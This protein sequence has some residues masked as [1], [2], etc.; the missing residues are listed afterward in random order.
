MA[1][2]WVNGVAHEVSVGTRLSEVLSRAPHPCGGKGICG[3]CRVRATGALSPL[4]REEERHLTAF[5]IADD[6][7]L[8]CCAVVE[9]DCRVTV[10]ADSVMAVIVDGK[11][12]AVMTPTFVTYGV[13]VDVGTTTL[14]ARL[15]DVAG[16]LLAQAGGINPQIA[17]GADILSRIQ[18]AGEGKDLTTPLQAAVNGLICRLAEEAGVHTSAIDGVVITGNTAMLC[19]LAGTDPTPLSYAPFALPHAFHETVT[20]A[21][22]GLTSLAPNRGVYLPPCASAF[23]GADALCAALACGMD[24]DD[25]TTLLA[26][27]GTNG[28][29]LLRHKNTLYACSTAAGPAFEGVGISCGMP[30]VE[31][32][33]DEVALVNGRLLSHTIGGGKAKGICGSGL[34]DAAACLLVTEEMDKTGYLGSVAVPLTENLSLTQED[35]RALQQAKAAVGA[36][37]QT[38][39][40]H[41]D[42]TADGVE[43]L[44]VAGGFGSR[45]NGR[46][47]AAIGLLPRDLATRIQPVGNAALDGASRLL[48]DVSAREKLTALPDDIHVIELATDL[49]FTEHFIKNMTF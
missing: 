43:V 40:H 39:L 38:L 7:R 47:A 33:I 5:E 10:E 29:L 13:A 42:L 8:S 31:G 46:N 17:F 11:P 45:L 20:A 37:L 24:A 30:A 3:K 26:D 19:F 1:T 35:V 6:I 32:A 18:T 23:I 14:A 27:M 25:R 12:T 16:R 22:I 28:E 34:V 21:A 15:Y 36:G 4:S 9:G 49:Y 41:A 44:Y 2:V 48:L